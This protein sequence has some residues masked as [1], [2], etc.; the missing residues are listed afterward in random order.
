MCGP[1]QLFSIGQSVAVF[2]Q[3][4]KGYGMPFNTLGTSSQTSELKVCA[5]PPP[6]KVLLT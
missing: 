6:E 2:I 3:I 5:R 1:I 4:E